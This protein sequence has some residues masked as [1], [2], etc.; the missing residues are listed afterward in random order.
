[1]ILVLLYFCSVFKKLITYTMKTTHLLWVAAAM[2][3][4]ACKNNSITI[5]GTVERDVDSLSVAVM[6]N[7]NSDTLLAKVPVTDGKYTWEGR[8]D[9]ACI[10]RVY[11]GEGDRDFYRVICEPGNIVLNIPK[12]GEAYPSGTPLNDSITAYFDAVAK[13]EEKNNALIGTYFETPAG[14]KHDSIEQELDVISKGQ[15][16]CMAGFLN[17]HTNDM[18]GIYLLREFQNYWRPEYIEET[19]KQMQQ[20]FPDNF[21][22]KYINEFVEGRLRTYPGRKYTDLKMATPDGGEL[23]LSD[24]VPNHRYTL[25][26]FWASWCRPCC[27]ELPNVK[28]VWEKYHDKGFEVVGVSFDGDA[29][30][31]K[32]A[33]AE[34]G[35]KWLNMSDLKGWGCEAAKVYGIRGIPRSLLIGQDG[36]IIDKDFRGDALM[37]KMDELMGND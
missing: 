36:I 8:V 1:M 7:D 15:A 27:A 32:K 14:E 37:K 3:L 10:L 23:S 30:A 25:V 9:S 12:E 6:L 35:I 28:A 2:L 5:S 26:D 4:A 18:F 20:N 24:V 16:Q 11:Y 19:T 21:W 33:I 29:E 34:Y 13:F 31:W 22:A 17:R